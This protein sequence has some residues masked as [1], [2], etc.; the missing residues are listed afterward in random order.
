MNMTD[1][2]IKECIDSIDFSQMVT[3]DDLFYMIARAVL[4]AS[5]QASQSEK[6]VRDAALEE[7]MTALNDAGHVAAYETVYRLLS[8][9]AQ[10]SK[11][12]KA[13]SRKYDF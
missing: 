4:S 9:P 3:A 12:T 1:E 8:T 11:K 6:A 13:H 2:Q 10:Q 7:A 5:G